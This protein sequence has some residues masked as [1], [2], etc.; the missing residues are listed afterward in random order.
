MRK[1]DCGQSI[2][3]LPLLLVLVISLLI[4][5]ISLSCAPKTSPT[6]QAITP[7]P[8]PVPQDTLSAVSTLVP[9]KAVEKTPSPV[10]ST[11]PPTTPSAAPATP[12]PAAKA[13]PGFVTPEVVD[14]SEVAYTSDSFSIKAY[15][16]R[17]KSAGT[18]PALIIIHENRGLQPHIEDVARRFANQGYIALAPDLLSRAGGTAQFSN[19]DDAVSAIG[20]LSQDGIVQDLNSAIKY[21][22]SLPYVKKDRIA[23]LG[24][25]WGGGNSLFFAT[26]NSEIKAAV[27]YY[28]PNPANLDDV[29]NITAPVLGIFGEKDPR[30]TVNVPKLEEAMKKYNKSFEYKVY[31]DALHAFFNNTGA[32]YNP[33]AAADAWPLTLSFLEKHLKNPTGE[34]KIMKQYSSPPSMIIDSKKAYTATMHTSKGDIVLELFSQEA[35]KTVNNF[36]FLSRDGF[37]DGTK[38]HRIIKDFM[39]QGGDPLGTGTGGPGYRFADEPV[40]RDYLSGIIAMANAGPNTNGSQFFIMH[41]SVNLPKNYTIFGKVTQGMDI[42]DKIA[43]TPVTRNSSG[44]PSQPTEDNIIRSMDISENTRPE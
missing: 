42:V 23:V 18:F 5:T 9:P 1:R 13:P 29:A 43:N 38:F 22:Q 20:R 10:P 16:S 35:P 44:E 12:V 17:P 39:I 33:E 26:R 8:L 6:P 31:P 30:I 28:G 3:R 2:K 15:L 24:Y 34:V 37:Y 36:I 41:K 19:T 21:L 11:P 14:S 7:A 4:T 27:V 32:N 25:C 40:K